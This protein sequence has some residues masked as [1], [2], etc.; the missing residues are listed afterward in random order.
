VVA[1]STLVEMELMA[2]SSGKQKGKHTT[3]QNSRRWHASTPASGVV[4]R[5]VVDV[6]EIVR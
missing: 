4:L 3:L 1:A 2:I 6:E 5:S